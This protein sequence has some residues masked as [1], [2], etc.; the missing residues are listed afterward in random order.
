MSKTAIS[1]MMVYN[2]GAIEQHYDIAY[3][4]LCCYLYDHAF[5]TKKS[6]SFIPIDFHI[7][8]SKSNLHPKCFLYQATCL[9]LTTRSTKQ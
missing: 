3:S 2:T 6:E 4:D 8:L 7:K 5:C 9:L 1:Y